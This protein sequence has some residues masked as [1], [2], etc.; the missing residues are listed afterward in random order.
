MKKGFPVQFESKPIF[1][2]FRIRREATS[3]LRPSGSLGDKGRPP[4]HSSPQSSI[5]SSMES[6]RIV[7]EYLSLTPS[8]IRS[9]WRRTFR[10]APE[11]HSPGVQN[12]FPALKAPRSDGSTPVCCNLRAIA[13][14]F[15]GDELVDNEKSVSL[16]LA[17]ANRSIAIPPLSAE[18]GRWSDLPPGLGTNPEVALFIESDGTG[19]TFGRRPP[20]GARVRS[21]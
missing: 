2:Y 9:Q 1:R 21:L 17:A 8:A 11:G 19:W 16:R 4:G 5:G 10:W 18:R 15:A 14:R 7:Y 13:K 6:P 12:R 20:V 3:S